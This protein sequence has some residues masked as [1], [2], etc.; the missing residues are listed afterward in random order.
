MHELL[1]DRGWASTQVVTQNEFI[2]LSRSLGTPWSRS[3]R[4]V[5][6]LVVRDRK[7]APALS[8]S[9]IYG[10][11]E[12]PLH[13]DYAHHIVPPRFVLLR[14]AGTDP[15]RPTMLLPFASLD[16]TAD[17]LGIL[18]RRVWLV[19]G[20]PIAFYAPVLSNWD[21]RVRWDAGCM[22]PRPL[23]SDAVRTWTQCLCKAA[24]HEFH[25]APNATLVIDNWRTLHGRAGVDMETDSARMLERIV[26]S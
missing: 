2:E 18:K 7:E 23:G 17:E 16:L 19:R 21:V 14:F 9:G 20:G 10:R 24:A 1:L 8:L 12:F 3:G 26:V 22:F 15:V 25:W 5:D 11:G 6:Q 13:T 4:I